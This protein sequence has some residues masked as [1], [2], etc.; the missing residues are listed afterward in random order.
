ML[1]SVGRHGLILASGT[2]ALMFLLAL[3]S[4]FFPAFRFRV[5]TG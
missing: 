3:I 2:L 4:R 1:P 5:T